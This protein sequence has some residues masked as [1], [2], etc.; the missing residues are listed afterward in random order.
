MLKQLKQYL[1]DNRN[2][3]LYLS[4]YP[5]TGSTVIS[6]EAI[7]RCFVTIAGIEKEFTGISEKDYDKLV[8]LYDWREKEN[9][10]ENI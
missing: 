6:K 7:N 1:K 4:L 5:E 2:E 9:S 10:N 8:P 3:V